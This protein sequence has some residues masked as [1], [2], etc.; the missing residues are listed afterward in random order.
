MTIKN[1]TINKKK[2]SLEEA[3][4]S[5]D[6]VHNLQEIIQTHSSESARNLGLSILSF[7]NQEIENS[8][9]HLESLVKENPEIVLLHQRIAEHCIDADKYEKAIIHLEKILELRKQDLTA[10]F[11]LCLIY[12]QLE[13]KEKA[14]KIFEYL[15]ENIYKIKVNNKNFRDE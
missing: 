2:F 10:R 3:C 12:Y 1:Q 4:K 7:F 11:W 14:K 13:Q 9:E 8:L 15:K 6:Y 5:P